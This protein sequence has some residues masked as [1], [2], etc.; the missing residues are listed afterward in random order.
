MT[1]SVTSNTAEH[2]KDILIIG[3]VP[4]ALLR[5]ELKDTREKSRNHR[6]SIADR[7]KDIFS[8]LKK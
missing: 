4:E 5:N 8:F 1:G 7:I 3:T 2:S 6:S